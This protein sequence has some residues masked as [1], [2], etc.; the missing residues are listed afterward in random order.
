MVFRH[1]ATLDNDKEHMDKKAVASLISCAT[2]TICQQDDYRVTNLFRSY[3]SDKDGLINEADFLAYWEGRAA[4]SCSGSHWLREELTNLYKRAKVEHSGVTEEEK[5]LEEGKEWLP[6][7]SARLAASKTHVSDYPYY[8]R[9]FRDFRTNDRVDV[10][11]RKKWQAGR[12]TTV[13]WDDYA[14]LV[15]LTSAS[16]ESSSN[17]WGAYTGYSS[18]GGYGGKLE[19]SGSREWLPVESEKLAEFQ[20]KSLDREDLEIVPRAAAA[21]PG[22]TGACPVPGACGLNNLG[23]TCFMNATVQAL[24]NTSTLRQYYHSGAYAQEIC[25]CPLSMNGRLASGFAELLGQLWSD[26]HRTISPAKLKALVAEKRP[27]FA[28]YQQHDAQELL[29]FLLDGL[30]EDGNRI[31]YPRPIVE[32]P[33]TEGKH[34][35]E[36]A[37]E[38]WDGYLRR[39]DSKIVEIFQFQ[40]RSEV[41]FPDIGVDATSLTFDPMMYLSLHVPKPPHTISITVLSQGY[42]SVAPLRKHFAIGKDKLFQDLEQVVL[43]GCLPHSR[44]A[45][46]PNSE[47]RCFVFADLYD[48]RVYRFF[49]SD[50]RVARVRPSD[51]VWAFEVPLL[52]EVPVETQE[53]CAVHFRKRARSGYGQHE[54]VSS[55]YTSDSLASFSR[56]GPPNIIAVR[57]GVTTNAEVIRRLMVLADAI[58]EHFGVDTSSAVSLTCTGTYNSSDVGSPLPEQGVFRFRSGEV[59]N[60]NFLDLDA[61]GKEVA[62]PEVI[63]EEG[64][65]AASAGGEGGVSL[66]QCLDS[67]HLC[68]ELSKDDWA[69]CRKTEQFERTL[70]RL[71]I[72]SVP[73]V[74]VV[75]L[76][77]FGRESLQGPLEKIETIVNCPMELDLLGWVAGPKPPDGARYRLFA[78][79]NHMGGLGGGHYTAH[80]MVGER[81]GA[82]EWY[83]FNDSTVQSAE[84]SS[85]V[86]KAT[87]ILFYERL[88]GSCTFDASLPPSGAVAA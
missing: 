34:D 51:N 55:W 17:S 62:L 12:V 48:N 50:E 18:Y 64:C 5:L 16:S 19:D 22:G 60:L 82:S 46:V 85:V 2:N 70:K 40:V 28:G 15:E 36:I 87:Y 69:W 83:H 76:K 88:D 56:M 33:K 57:P 43:A 58:R 37:K 41:T 27:E 8:R 25:R 71:Q 24:S 44:R 30:H 1:Y 79:V 52:P 21:A 73:Q 59:L 32:D 39:N 13:D 66:E 31:G 53:F 75:H 23:N 6:R 80:A 7:S 35:Q 10:L 81:P 45:T 65:A 84:E 14:V 26:N 68:E 63:V 67:Y 3:D 72:W 74:L 29:T 9:S 78:T 77:R 11:V 49:H 86:S 4:S 47:E 38:A 61:A 20:T 42:P 54:S